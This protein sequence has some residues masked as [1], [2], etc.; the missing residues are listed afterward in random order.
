MSERSATIDDRLDGVD[1][2]RMPDLWPAAV[3]R[4]KH[5]SPWTSDLEPPG[6]RRLIA[7]ATALALAAAAIGVLVWSFRD[8]RS[9]QPAAPS[10]EGY[11]VTL[12]RGPDSLPGV[13]NSDLVAIDPATGTRWN[14]TNT[15]EAESEPAWSPDGSH[16]AFIRTT[17]TDGGATFP[18]GVFAMDVSTGATR[19][20]YP[21]EDEPC[22]IGSMAWSPDDR[23]LAIV[24]MHPRPGN[25]SVRFTSSARLVV[26][27][28]ADGRRT[29]LCPGGSCALALRSIA[30]SP[31]GSQIAFAGYPFILI[32]IG[33]PEPSS[34]WVAN[35]DGSDL[36]R[37]TEGDACRASKD[38]CFSDHGV[39]WS[40]D[41]SQIAFVR[42]SATFR[43]GGPAPPPPEVV[44]V[45]PNGGTQ[46]VVTVCNQDVQLCQPADPMWS[47]DGSEIVTAIGYHPRTVIRVNVA[48]GRATTVAAIANGPC[49]YEGA[50]LSWSPDHR[51]IAYEGGPRGNNACVIP[52]AGGDPRVLVRDFASGDVYADFSWIPGGTLTPP[53]GTPST[54]PSPTIPLAP[55]PVGTLVFASTNASASGPEGSGIW[56][57]SSAEPTPRLVTDAVRS[58][59]QPC[60]SSDGTRIVFAGI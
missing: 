26:I 60:I 47:A 12:G 33:G 29:T 30:W 24:D 16:V 28:P 19:E 35:A 31:D 11:V 55:L 51:S 6:H 49:Q 18:S 46:H 23:S 57:V 48:T 56:S 42:E 38:P 39:A 44:V 37:V 7:A 43:P 15:P 58:A 21:C 9:Q 13:D 59:R 27:H 1:R 36:R 32:G 5:D 40:P 2:T 54:G 14:L 20:V 8:T 50:S 4:A 25:G 3:D 17:T 53:A 10:G 41:G 34:V 22:R 45:P 52:A